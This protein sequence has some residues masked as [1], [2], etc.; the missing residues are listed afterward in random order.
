LT[1]K[2]QSNLR[3]V[4]LLPNGRIPDYKVRRFTV[5]LFL[6]VKR[7][8]LRGMSS[9]RAVATSTLH[10]RGSVTSSAFCGPLSLPSRQ[11]TGRQRPAERELGCAGRVGGAS[12]P[13]GPP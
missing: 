1:I 10:T 11:P 12:G 7:R 6:T 3:A 13:S 5:N 9:P 2:C 8:T 4:G